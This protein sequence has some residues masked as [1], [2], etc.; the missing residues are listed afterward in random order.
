MEKEVFGGVHSVYGHVVLSFGA[1]GGYMIHGFMTLRGLWIRYGLFC[2]ACINVVNSSQAVPDE[3][4]IHLS[5][6]C[7]WYLEPSDHV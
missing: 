7:Y 6:M 1:T 2:L 3:F 5:S 4:D